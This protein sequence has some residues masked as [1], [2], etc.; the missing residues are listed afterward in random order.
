MTSQ[1]DLPPYARLQSAIPF[2]SDKPKTYQR[3]GFVRPPSPLNW[4]RAGS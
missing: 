4:L 1:S 3:Q 2:G